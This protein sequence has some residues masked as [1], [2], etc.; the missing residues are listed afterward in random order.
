MTVLLKEET[1]TV[2][3][4]LIGRIKNLIHGKEEKIRVVYVKRLRALINEAFQ[5]YVFYLFR[6]MLCK[7][8]KFYYSMII[9]EFHNSLVYSEGIYIL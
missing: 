8:L 2:C 9:I 1:L 4:W 3:T 7:L 6:V 5:I